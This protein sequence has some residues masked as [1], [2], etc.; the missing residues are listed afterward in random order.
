[1]KTFGVSPA[2]DTIEVIV[3]TGDSI[4]RIPFKRKSQADKKIMELTR[5]GYTFDATHETLRGELGY[6]QGRGAA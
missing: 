6:M 5:A 4:E 3:R 1:M 2:A